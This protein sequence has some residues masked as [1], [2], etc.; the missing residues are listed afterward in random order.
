MLDKDI[1]SI[2][3]DSKEQSVTV[4]VEVEKVHRLTLVP[5]TRE[6]IRQDLF[7]SSLAPVLKEKGFIVFQE[8]N[9]RIPTFGSYSE[10][11]GSAI[12]G[13]AIDLGF[14]HSQ[15]HCHGASI[16]VWAV[17]TAHHTRSHSLSKTDTVN[18]EMASIEIKW[19]QD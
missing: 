15:K 12:D 3:L 8:L 11:A 4:T 10:Y 19:L 2:L 5:C 17:I 18:V 14:Y 6:L 16:T 9:K 13:S 7:F 1:S